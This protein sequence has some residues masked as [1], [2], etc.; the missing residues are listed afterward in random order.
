MKFDDFLV[1]MSKIRNKP[2]PGEKSHFKMMPDFR[3]AELKKLSNKKL[4]ARKAGVLVLFYP[5]SDGKAKLILMLRKTY[6]GVHSNQ[7]SF[8]GGKFEPSDASIED[9]ALRETNEELGIAIDTIEVVKPLSQVF[10]PPSNFLVSPFLGIARTNM[11]F[12][13]QEREVEALVEVFLSDIMDETNFFNH[14]ITTSYAKD[15]DVP[16][17][18]LNGYVV[19]GA[20]A[21]MLNEVKDLLKESI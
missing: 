5:D 11:S 21:M 1:L 14:N 8:P 6:N 9:T 18:K 16:A 3:I 19:W 10:I 2:L 4:V 17:F 7:I 20:T 15:I 12:I 13:P